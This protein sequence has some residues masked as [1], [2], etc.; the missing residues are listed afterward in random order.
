MP[1]ADVP[2]PAP[3]A[4]PDAP[5]AMELVPPAS[6][7]YRELVPLIAMLVMSGADAQ[8]PI[9]VPAAWAIAVR[10]NALK[11]SAVRAARRG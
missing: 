3:L 7:Q 6:V 2:V 8:V 9:S 5:I 1:L 4:L 10:L 11:A